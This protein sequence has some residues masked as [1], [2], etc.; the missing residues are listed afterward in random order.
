MSQAIHASQK[1]C[2]NIDSEIFVVDN[3]STDGSIEMLEMDFPDIKIIQNKKNVGFSKANNQAIKLAKGKFILLLNPDTVV[4][5]DTFE[6]CISFMEKMP[7]CG[8]LGVRMLDGAGNFLPES[9]RSLPQP[10]VAFYKIFGLSKL[11]PKSKR[12]G[13]YHL[14]FLDEHQNHEVEILAGAFM[15]CRK[16]VLDEIG[17]L[18]ETYFMYG[19]DIDLSYRVILGG[20]KNYFCAETSIIHYKGESTK[21]Q[22]VNY[23]RIFYKAMV[24]FAQKYFSKSNARTFAFLINFAIFIRAGLAIFLGFFK[25]VFSPILDALLLFAGMFWLKEFWEKYVKYEEQ[26]IYPDLLMQA[27]VPLYIFIWLGSVYF[28]GGYDK[29]FRATKM[30]RGLLVG[31]VLISA[32]Y[33]FFDESYRF[34][35]GLILAGTLLAI[36]IIL[37]IRLLLQFFQEGNFKLNQEEIKRILVLGNQSETNRLLSLLQQAHVPSKFL[38][39]LSDDSKDEKEEF[40]L[41]STD[42]IKNIIQLFEVN[43]IIFCGNN[44]SNKKIITWIEELKSKKIEFKILPEKSLS[45]IHI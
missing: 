24:I 20:F 30:I 4:A 16:K 31:T 18:D 41:D 11:F 5:E 13:R 7:K 27:I 17:L 3:A 12:Y 21:K 19:E 22:S 10:A 44:F 43:E 26:I 33:G 37:G 1:A 32:I 8:A 14:T 9:K 25:K 36:C 35:R 39:F 38:G 2:K 6:K 42:N 40:Y 28:S 29:P 23:I 15:F 45:L 34:S